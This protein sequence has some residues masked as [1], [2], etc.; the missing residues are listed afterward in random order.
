MSDDMEGRVVI[1]EDVEEVQRVFTYIM[2]H[3]YEIIDN[4]TLLTSAFYFDD[5]NQWVYLGTSKFKTISGIII[6][7][8]Y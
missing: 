3:Q 6:T 2:N 8:P 1:F 5:I 4:Y 7:I